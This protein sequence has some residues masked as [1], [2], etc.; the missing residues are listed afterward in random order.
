MAAAITPK[1]KALG[2]GVT[3]NASMVDTS[4]ANTHTK[5]K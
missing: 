2:F 3:N 1:P 5:G 4:K